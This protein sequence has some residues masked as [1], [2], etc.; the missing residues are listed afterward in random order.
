V[1]RYLV[2]PLSIKGSD[3][4]IETIRC[5]RNEFVD[6]PDESADHP[7]DTPR[8]TSGRVAIKPSGEEFDLPAGLVM[9]AIGYTGLPL[10][11]VPFDGGQGVVPNTGGR[12]L[13]GPGGNRVEG[14]YV[15]GWIKRGA[16]GGIG[17]NRLCGQET[18]MA[19]IADFTE[20]KLPEP[21]S[22]RECVGALVAK[23]TV[24]RVDRVGWKKIDVV[25]RTAGKRVGRPRIK[26][27][28]FDALQIA[29]ST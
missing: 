7:G 22:S 29:A 28:N 2:S 26:L 8:P 10:D 17:M 3:D 13:D 9:R 20:G 18:A 14:V 19:V 11:G 27:V 24:E 15:T 5:V 1:F 16:T 21:A 6:A 12:V 25:E 4:G 23:R